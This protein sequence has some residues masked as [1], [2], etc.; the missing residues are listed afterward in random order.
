MNAAL[1]AS[2]ETVSSLLSWGADPD[3]TIAGDQTALMLAIQSKCSTTIN[4]LAKK[5]NEKIG[6][7]LYMLAREK[8]TTGELRQLVERAAQDREA[9][10]EGLEAAAMFGSSAMIAE[11]AMF[12]TDKSIFEEHQQSIWLEAVNSDSAATVSALL[13]LLPNPPLE[14]TT[15]AR[16]RGC[17]GWS[18]YFYQ[19]PMLRGKRRG[20]P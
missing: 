1:N 2:D 19:T 3:I 5:T 4:L 7:A 13:L 15:L 16:E 11:L 12:I 8:V 18:S 10:I 9:A 14:V 17:Q 20:R 6:G